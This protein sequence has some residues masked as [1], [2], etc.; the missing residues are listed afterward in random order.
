MP[1]DF[2]L[3][4]YL[5]TKSIPKGKVSTYSHIAKQ[6]DSSPRAVATALGRNPY[7]SVPCHRVV[8]TTGRL[9][10]YFRNKTI[11]AL[12]ERQLI[13][14]QEGIEFASNYLVKASYII[15]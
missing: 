12:E 15:N 7:K 14:E 11:K 6:I 8:T 13:L 9:T 5:H 2:Q 4:V 10:G 1:T 3:K